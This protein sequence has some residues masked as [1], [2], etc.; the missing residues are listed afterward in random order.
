MEVNGC[1]PTCIAV[2]LGMGLECK[3]TIISQEQRVRV[4]GMKRKTASE[5]KAGKFWKAAT[6][7]PETKKQKTKV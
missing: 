5:R 6:K 4:W 3:R 1:Y 2:N 7:L